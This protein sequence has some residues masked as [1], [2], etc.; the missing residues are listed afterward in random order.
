MEDSMAARGW[1]RRVGSVALRAVERVGAVL[2]I[3]GSGLKGG[4][5]ADEGARALNEKPT[6]YRP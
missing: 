4:R 1:A 3:I 2:L 5:S 6:D